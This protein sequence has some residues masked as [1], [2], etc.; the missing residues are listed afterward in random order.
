M[1]YYKLF[2]TSV[3]NHVQL[4][5]PFF[6]HKQQAIYLIKITPKK[7]YN[8]NYMNLCCKHS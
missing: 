3:Y 1:S 6:T 5:Q 8:A 2:T 7:K 4:S